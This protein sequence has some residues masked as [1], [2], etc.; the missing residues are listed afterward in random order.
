VNVTKAREDNSE[1]SRPHDPDP[2]AVNELDPD[3]INVV[4]LRSERKG[5][6]L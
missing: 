3:W 4:L 1:Q 6:E 2:D 5:D